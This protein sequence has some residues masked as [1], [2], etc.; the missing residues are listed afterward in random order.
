MKEL[1]ANKAKKLW[2]FSALFAALALS[3]PLA[4]SFTGIFEWSPFDF[5][6]AGVLLIGLAIIINLVINYTKKP[7]LRWLFLLITFLLFIL[8]WIELAV[9]LFGSPLSG[10]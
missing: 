4:L 5:L 2:L 1:T 10:S 3:I 8:L 6:I 9:G 7:T